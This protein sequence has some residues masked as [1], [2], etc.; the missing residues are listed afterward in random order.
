MTGKLGSLVRVRYLKLPIL[1]DGLF[2]YLQAVGSRYPP[3]SNITA[4]NVYYRRQNKKARGIGR[5][6]ISI[7]QT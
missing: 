4:V 1:P 7:E 6:V 2:C 5:Y 3:A